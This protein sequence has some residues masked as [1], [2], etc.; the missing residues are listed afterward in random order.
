[1][2][3]FYNLDID[4]EYAPNLGGRHAHLAREGERQYPL[5][6]DPDNRRPDVLT[7]SLAVTQSKHRRR[8]NRTQ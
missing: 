1:M 8:G 4:T 5:Q 3:I 7:R 6:A 2:F